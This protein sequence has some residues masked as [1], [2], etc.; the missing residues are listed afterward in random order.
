MSDNLRN[1]AHWSIKCHFLH[2]ATFVSN[3]KKMHQ[4]IHLCMYVSLDF[5]WR[6]ESDEASEVIKDGATNP[7]TVCRSLIFG[8]CSLEEIN[9]IEM[10]S[11]LLSRRCSPC[12]FI[13]KGKQNSL[14]AVY[15][16]RKESV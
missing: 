2:S 12:H 7:H 9:N 5:F 16:L 3:T 10:Y 13:F 11:P 6:T 4:E 14:I 15:P 1:N 8:I